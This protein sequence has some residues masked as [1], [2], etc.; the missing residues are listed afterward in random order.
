S[1]LF[2]HEKGA[3]TGAVTARKGR[4]ELADGGTLFLDEIGEISASFQ[5]KLLRVLQEGEFE[6]VG[7]TR[8]LKVNVRIVA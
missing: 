7:G 3:F 5:A 4:F 8:T 2:G 1:E 6:R